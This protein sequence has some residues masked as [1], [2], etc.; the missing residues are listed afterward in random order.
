MKFSATTLAPA[1]VAVFAM[2][3]FVL[4]TPTPALFQVEHRDL[5]KRCWDSGFCFY[6]GMCCSGDC[7]GIVSYRLNDNFIGIQ[8]ADVC[9]SVYKLNRRNVDVK[10][11]WSESVSRFGD[12]IVFA[13]ASV[14]VRVYCSGVRLSV[15]CRVRE[16]KLNRND[17]KWCNWEQLV[18]QRQAQPDSSS[19]PKSEEEW[20][21]AVLR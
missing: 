11:W 4:T 21:G 9:P 6:D 16:K 14:R 8:Y 5:N 17:A 19:T 13:S 15:H 1:V 12:V 18:W 7:K 2:C 20:A 10:V 3:S